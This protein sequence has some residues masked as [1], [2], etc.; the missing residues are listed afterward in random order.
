MM[1]YYYPCQVSHSRSSW[2]S[3]YELA[4]SD[5][6]LS[7]PFDRIMTDLDQLIR[8]ALRN[9]N[10]RTSSQFDLTKYIQDFRTSA[11]EKAK[12]VLALLN[13]Q[14]FPFAGRRPVFVSIGGGDGE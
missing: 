14:N 6:L 13:E 7:I 8:N 5:Y 10:E 11:R 2:V 12:A 3:Q 9:V 1:A 4:T